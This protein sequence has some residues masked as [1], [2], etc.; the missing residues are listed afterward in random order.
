MILQVL[1]IDMKQKLKS[2]KMYELGKSGKYYSSKKA[3]DKKMR[4]LE[5][6]V[7]LSV[8]RGF[9]FTLVPLNKSIYLQIDV[10]SRILQSRNLL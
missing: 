8:I 4:E 5:E 6:S 3:K 9:K 1:N 7:K 2:L 10:C